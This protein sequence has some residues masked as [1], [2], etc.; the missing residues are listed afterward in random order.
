[1]NEDP[2]GAYL[3]PSYPWSLDI[4]LY[5]PV[6]PP[7]A[8]GLN[9]SQEKPW[10]YNQEGKKSNPK[11]GEKY[12]HAISNITSIFFLSQEKNFPKTSRRM[13]ELFVWSSSV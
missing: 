6:D 10:S 4:F 12:P 13:R 1:M 9:W 3:A 8:A 2:R 11:M 5:K 7:P